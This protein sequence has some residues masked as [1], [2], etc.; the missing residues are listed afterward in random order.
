M[1]NIIRSTIPNTGMKKNKSITKIAII[2]AEII[3]AMT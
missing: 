2:T 1:A 3:L